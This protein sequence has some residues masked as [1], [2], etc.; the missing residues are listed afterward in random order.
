MRLLF[1]SPVFPWPQD[2]GTRVRI[3][4][5]MA[6]LARRGHEIGLVSNVDAR[7]ADHVARARRELRDVRVVESR[8]IGEP[9]QYGRMPF[10]RALR[11]GAGLLR[12]EPLFSCLSYRPEFEAA[13]RELAP[14]YDHVFVEF[15]FMAQNVPDDVLASAPWRFSLVEHDISFVPKRRAFDVAPWTEKP[16]RWLTYRSWRRAESRALRRF[17]TIIAM[18][19]HD[20]EMLLRLAPGR[21]IIVAPNGVDVDRFHPGARQDPTPPPGLLFV[22]GLGHWPNLDA[23]EHFIRDYMPVLRR[24]FPGITFTVAGQTDGWPGV[25]T[26]PP[27]V[28]FAG[29][30]E[31]LEPLYAACTAVVAPLRIGGGTRL[32]IVEAMAAGA[33]VVTTAVGAEG[34]DLVD[35]QTAFFAES[36][37]EMAGA[38]DALA[39]EPGLAGRISAAARNLCRERYDWDSIAAGLES[40]ISTIKEGRHALQYP[41]ESR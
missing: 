37:E 30:V 2:T 13:V 1:L 39:G 23:V 26:A 29:F 34:L 14:Q 7:G 27:D 3:A 18:S 35:G 40:E 41:S 25:Q 6:A 9:V 22:G 31:N 38:L 8:R 21:R 5:L 24:R 16:G 19:G 15:Y 28:R 32:K 33:P 10:G 20:R 11:V 4:R 17:E 36:P 12:G